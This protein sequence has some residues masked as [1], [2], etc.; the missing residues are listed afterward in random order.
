MNKRGQ[1][2]I[3]VGFILLTAIMVY[4][5]ALAPQLSYW[6]AEAA[7]QTSG[8]ESVLWNNLNLFVVIGLIMFA[9]IGTYVVSNQ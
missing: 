4:A 8:I 5:L 2:I 7:S 1:T 3:T 6:G 9:A